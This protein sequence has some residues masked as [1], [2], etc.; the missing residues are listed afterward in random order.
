[1]SYHFASVRMADI[2][3]TKDNN[4]LH[5]IPMFIAAQFTI[6]KIQKQPKCPF[7]DEWI[8]KIWYLHSIF[9]HTKEKKRKEKK[10]LPFV[11][12]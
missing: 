9:S 8:K 1:M 12:T 3:K 2:K 4:Q 7:T 10:V 6:D 5:S 11:A